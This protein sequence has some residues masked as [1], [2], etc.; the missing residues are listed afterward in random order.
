MRRKSFYLAFFAAHFFFIIVISTRELFWVLSRSGTIFPTKFNAYW[1]K[2]ENGGSTLLAQNESTP[3]PLREALTTYFHVAG[4]ETGY[5]FFAPN[6]S[7]AC[8]LV[9]ELHYPDGRTE[10]QV[11]TVSSDASGLR[12]ATMLDKIGRPQ[13]D[14]FREI[15]MKMLA[16]AVWREHSDANV[17]RAVF[18]IVTL[19]TL[20]EFKQ[21]L[22]ESNEVLYVYDFAFKSAEH[23][24]RNP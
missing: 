18:G 16:T 23:N 14:P 15:A 22:R 20:D 24:E 21:G 6:V 10:S 8:K 9:F 2:V 13:S 7:G 1:E 5:G 11:P 19:P 17:I 4:I 12:V 3:K